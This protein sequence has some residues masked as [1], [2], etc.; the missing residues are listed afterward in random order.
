MV[1]YYI[2]SPSVTHIDTL[3]VA[4]S[5]SRI[6]SEQSVEI[7]PILATLYEPFF[8]PRDDDHMASWALS[9]DISELPYLL[10]YNARE[11]IKARVALMLIAPSITELPFKWPFGRE[12]ATANRSLNFGRVPLPVLRM[13]LAAII[14]LRKLRGIASELWTYHCRHINYRPFLLELLVRLPDGHDRDQAFQAYTGPADGWWCGFIGDINPSR[15]LDD[16]WKL[17]ALPVLPLRYKRAADGLVQEY[18]RENLK[19]SGAQRWGDE[20]GFQMYASMVSELISTPGGAPYDSSLAEA[21]I[22]FLLDLGVPGA[23]HGFFPDRMMEAFLAIGDTELR[24]RLARAYVLGQLE[25][26][27]GL[28]CTRLDIPS[29]VG[30]PAW[31]FDVRRLLPEIRFAQVE[32]PE[33]RDANQ[34]LLAMAAISSGYCGRLGGETTEGITLACELLEACGDDRKMAAALEAIIAEVQG[35]P[36]QV[37]IDAGRRAGYRNAATNRL[38]EP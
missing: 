37:V 34:A 14:E 7:V 28:P 4:M 9:H 24:R 23:F 21:Q 35:S 38:C 11:S 13:M 20:T 19:D 25:C 29:R 3:V 15:D 12:G 32:R 18:V 36:D 8:D 33:A 1:I 10:E 22:R 2:V 31:Q 26:P 6:S 17:M 30:F 16:F 27:G 5:S